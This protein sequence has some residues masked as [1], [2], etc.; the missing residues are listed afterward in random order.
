MDH[1]KTG[2]FGPFEYWTTKVSDI[3]MN[4][5]FGCPVYGWLLY[6]ISFI[7]VH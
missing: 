7:R 3:Q 6:T 1:S 2:N 4:P 5:E